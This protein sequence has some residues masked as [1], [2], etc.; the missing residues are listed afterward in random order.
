M[1]TGESLEL[2]LD[3]DSIEWGDAWHE[4]IDSSLATIA[5]FIPVLTPRFFMKPECR[6]EL[7]FF[8][9][10]ATQLGSKELILPLLYVDFPS[11]H[12]DSPSDDL[13]AL[14]STFQWEDW[15]GLRFDD[16]SAGGYRRGVFHLAERLVDVNKR[17]E[18]TAPSFTPKQDISQADDD[19]PGFIDQVASAEET[20]PKLTETIEAVGVDITIIGTAM[21]ETTEAIKKSTSS[22]S[23]A[24]RLRL[25][26]QLTNQLTEPAE[27]LFVSGQTYVS[28]L[29]EVDQGFRAII[30]RASAEIENSPESLQDICSFFNMMKSLSNAAHEGIGAMQGMIDAIPAI[31]GL[32]RDL[33]PVLRRI[34]Q[35]LTTIV[36]GR[37]V[38]DEWILLIENSGIQCEA[39]NHSDLLANSE[40]QE[41]LSKDLH[42]QNRKK[43][44]KELLLAPPQAGEDSDFDRN[45]DRGR[46]VEL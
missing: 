45:P 16:I 46:D 14:V 25:A 10:K 8:A 40:H 2:F 22:G 43:T 27:R 9:R 7:Q 39:V 15:T 28:Q 6:R 34:R 23:Y 24:T 41:T 5:F 3:K 13:M 44:L 30:A 20:L 32:S 11:L 4:A 35:G 26:K 19:L 17:L 33:R 38:S 42:P 12:E 18:K 1:L 37:E 31:E 36:E 29:H 21:K